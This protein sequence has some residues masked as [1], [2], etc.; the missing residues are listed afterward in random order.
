MKSLSPSSLNR[1]HKNNNTGIQNGDHH[2][3]GGLVRSTPNKRPLPVTTPHNKS[4]NSVRL[5]SPKGSSPFIKRNGALSWSERMH[6]ICHKPNAS[7]PNIYYVV[8]LSI[9]FLVA[10][11]TLQKRIISSSTSPIATIDTSHF[12]T[13]SILPEAVHTSAGSIS[14]FDSTWHHVI[15]KS[16]YQPKSSNPISVIYIGRSWSSFESMIHTKNADAKDDMILDALQRSTY[17]KVTA[18]Y[19][20]SS[21]NITHPMHLLSIQQYHQYSFWNNNAKTPVVFIVDWSALGRDCHILERILYHILH[22]NGSTYKS[23][24]NENVYLLLLDSTASSHALMCS[25]SKILKELIQNGHQDNVRLAKRSIITNRRY[26]FTKQWVESGTL[27]PNPIIFT[28]S[29]GNKG[30]Q[31]RNSNILHWSGY[32]SQPFVRLLDVAINDGTT[33][34]KNRRWQRH[35]Q[36]DQRNTHFRPINVTHYW[37]SVGDAT[38]VKNEYQYY[39]NRLRQTVQQQMNTTRISILKRQQEDKKPKRKRRLQHDEDSSVSRWVEFVGIDTEVE[40]VQSDSS[41][42]GSNDDE[43][44]VEGSTHDASLAR[45]SVHVAVLASSKIVVVS[46]ADEYEDHDSRLIEALASGAMVLC[47]TMVAPPLGLVHKTNIVF[48]N[49]TS[50][51]DHYLKFYLDPKNDLQRQE[52]ARHGMEYA[53]GRHRSWH[54]IEALLFGKALTRTDKHPLMDKGPE[55]RESSVKHNHPVLITV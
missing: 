52:I 17:T 20:Y 29:Q 3:D 8:P 28:T 44:D 43:S 41:Q 19:L 10:F 47:D 40:L 25:D 22:G 42:D 39:Y 46:Q 54:A 55:T 11:T 50:K 53:L 4:Y 23:R 38:F 30:T 15:P 18:S 7:A 35:Q 51:L 21:N 5:R 49:S 24:S 33:Q 2:N 48:F 36:Q 45:S 26:N 32:V 14:T 13:T 16:V 6:R 27:I 9:L 12:V 1:L 34:S 37:K 31:N